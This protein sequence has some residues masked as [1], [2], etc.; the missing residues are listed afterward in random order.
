MGKIGF[1]CKWSEYETKSNS[2]TIVSVPSHNYKTT[3]L[4]WVK[5]QKPEV[6]QAKLLEI[7]KHN[8]V[9]T[10]NLITS[11]SK[12]PECLRMV[13]LGSDIL[14]LFTAELASSFW[15]D[16][17]VRQ[18]CYKELTRIGAQARASNI[19]LSMHPAQFCVL[20]SDDE[21]IVTKS[22]GELE[23]H[24]LVARLLG[25]AAKFQDFKINVH[26]SGRGGPEV[27]RR[28]YSKLTP[29]AR[30][31]LTIEN[32]EYTSNLSQCLTIADLVPIVLDVHHHMLHDNQWIDDTDDRIKLIE[33]SWRGVRPVV[34]YSQSRAEFHSTG[35]PLA[36]EMKTSVQKL[37]AHSDM[38]HNKS[39][40]SWMQQHTRWSDIMVEA[41]GKNL[42]STV[43]ATEWGMV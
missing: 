20:A 32:D 31:C 8:L 38:M 35:M 7:T 3:T 6:A 5:N 12:L 33:S 27:F 26:L 1:A 21:T 2:R 34:H 43:L 11:V 18:L 29:E 36:T 22:I 14:P 24:T 41:K 23:Y 25:Y 28:A 30:M 42:A 40:N 39:I 9:A 16:N 13:R 37:R 10:Q 4:S 19:R 15:R 17:T